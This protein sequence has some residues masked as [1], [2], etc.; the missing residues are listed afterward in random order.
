MNKKCFIYRCKCCGAIF[1]RNAKDL[2]GVE[3]TTLQKIKNLDNL[4]I[5]KCNASSSLVGIGELI[6]GTDIIR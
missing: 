2:I 3:S 5:H 4:Q 6:G 1:Y